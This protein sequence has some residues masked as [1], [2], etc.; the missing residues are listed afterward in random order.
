MLQY[1]LYLD[2]EKN[3][4]KLDDTNNKNNFSQARNL[5]RPSLRPTFLEQQWPYKWKEH[6]K[7]EA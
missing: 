6:K 5:M 4:I 2:D 7:R 1:Q 3:K